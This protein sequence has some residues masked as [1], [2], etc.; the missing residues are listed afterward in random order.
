MNTQPSPG[1]LVLIPI[2]RFET[3]FSYHRR[4][5]SEYRIG[6]ILQ[7]LG[8]CDSYLIYV[9]FPTLGKYMT[10]VFDSSE[11]ELMSRLSP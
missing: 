5:V 8:Y 1:D 4:F 11:F 6:V 7:D 3:R 10:S 9:D 2:Y